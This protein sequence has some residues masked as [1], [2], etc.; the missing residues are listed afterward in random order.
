MLLAHKIALD[1]NAEQRI[2]FARA[3]G[4]ARTITA[5]LGQIRGADLCPCCA[6]LV[7]FRHGASLAVNAAGPRAA[8]AALEMIVAELRH[9]DRSLPHFARPLERA[10]RQ[11]VLTKGLRTIFGVRGGPV[12]EPGA[13]CYSSVAKP[14]WAN[15]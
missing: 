1:P 15:T 8:V 11:I 7:L 9:L 14:P 2:Y 13:A 6:A 10:K 12:K 5:A 4:A 3:I